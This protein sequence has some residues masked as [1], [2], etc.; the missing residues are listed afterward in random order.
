[1][2]SLFRIIV[3]IASILCMCPCL[4]AQ[5]ISVDDI[6]KKR[7]LTDEQCQSLKSMIPGGQITPDVIQQYKQLSPETIQQLKQSQET[8]EVKSED[9]QRVKDLLQLKE[10][11]KGER[12]KEIERQVQREEEKVISE[13]VKRETLFKRSRMTGQYQNISTD[14]QPFGYEFFQEAAVK[15]TTDRK[16]VPVPLKYVVGPGDEVKIL[17]WGRVNAQYSLTVDRDGKITIPQIGP[18]FVAGMTF[19]DMSKKV[20]TQTGQMV[21]ANI[22]ITLGSLKSIPVFILG[23]VRRPGAYNIGSTAT[24]TDAL[25]LAGGPSD[26]G[27]MREIQLRRKNKVITTLD[28]YDL[29]LKGDKSKDAVIQADDVVFVPVTGPLAGIAGNV[30]RPAI[31]ELKSRFDLQHLFDLAGGILPTAYTQQIQVSRIQKNERQIVIDIDDKHLS[32]AKDVKL[33]DADLVNVFTIVDKDLN[34]VYLNGNVKRPGKYEYKPGMKIRDLIKAPTDLLDE[35][36]F[37]YA[38]IKRIMPPDRRTEYV[39]FNLGRLLLDKD[40]LQN[41][42]LQPEDAITIFSKWLLKDKPYVTVEGEVRGKKDLSKKEGESDLSKKKI[43]FKEKDQKTLAGFAQPNKSK[44]ISDELNRSEKNLKEEQKRDERLAYADKFKDIGDE[45]KKMEKMDLYE[46]V[47]DIENDIRK[48]DEIELSENIRNIESELRRM[49]RYDLANKILTIWNSLRKSIRIDISENMRIKDALMEVGGLTKDAFL[50]QGEVVRRLNE[51]KEYVTIYFNV[52]KAISGDPQEN[53]LIQ[54][55]DKIIIHAIWEHVGSKSVFIDGEVTK[56]GS[57]QYT[58]QMRVRDLVFKAGNVLDSAYVGDAELS[59]QI[60][61]SGKIVRIEHRKINLQEALKGNPIHNVPLKPFDHLF[62]KR[63]ANWGAESY[64]NVSGELFFPGRYIIRKGEKLSALIERAGG[65]TDKAYLRG[66]VFKRE[67]VRELQQKGLEDM[68]KRM[69]ND[70]LI[71]GGST[72]ST[73]LSKEEVMAKQTELTQKQK[74]IANLYQLKAQGRMS[75]NLSNLRLL[76][77]SEYDIELEDNDSLYIPQKASAVNVSGA[78][79]SQGSYLYNTKLDVDDYISMAGGYTRYADS[80]NSYI[81]KVDGSARRVSSGFM[82]WNTNKSR[83]ELTAFGEKIMEIE[84]G[85][86]IV[87]PEKM[88]RIAWLREVRD[89]TQILMQMAVT[90]G[91]A[92]KM[93]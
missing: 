10:T 36:Y 87:V 35:T 7:N 47:K 34:A 45:I 76:K 50:D 14:L 55:R 21:G 75:I 44:D 71:E 23:D 88:E 1:M 58:E 92:I 83:W 46:K 63:I 17:L 60:V 26:I 93:F 62:V 39:P 85:D 15:V 70:M 42:N 80:D 40:E 16:D 32:K 25:I 65:Y 4:Y 52:A 43:D 91:I 11:E 74:F 81:L 89:I 57:Y 38:L 66:A 67:S 79:M 27:S 3:V 59:S 49:G 84:P 48:K 54:D 82:N 29:F 56:R 9:I 8:K 90:A 33:Q 51:G 20:I 73:S 69:E 18:I 53:F 24:I 5:Q 61:E 37:E 28:L 41:I 13:E 78:V 19:E 68:I 72:I 31:Y 2:I 86:M 22:D 64:V 30:R 12:K 77:G 6:C